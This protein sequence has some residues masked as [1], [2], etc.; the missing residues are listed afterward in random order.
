M[1]NTDTKTYVNGRHYPLWQQFVDRKS[2]W[3]GGTLQE[4]DQILGEGPLCEI[5][6]ISLEPS[7][8]DSAFF[9]IHGKTLKFWE[10][11]VTGTEYNCGADVRYFGI[12]GD[13][14]APWLTFSTQ[15]GDKFRIKRKGE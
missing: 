2:E 5:T 3:I 1:M 12:G 4:I 9:Q 13:Q 6:D 8:E 11:Y 7:D 15:W 10:G 14:E